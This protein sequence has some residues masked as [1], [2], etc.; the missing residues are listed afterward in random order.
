MSIPPPLGLL[1]ASAAVSKSYR[2]SFIQG[3]NPLNLDLYWRCDRV[4]NLCLT[5]SYNH[6]EGKYKNDN[7]GK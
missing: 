2:Y 6:Q 7:E 4:V 5:S 1:S 3:L